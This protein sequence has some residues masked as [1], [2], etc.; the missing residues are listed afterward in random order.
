MADSMHLKNLRI[1]KR[2]ILKLKEIIDVA[3]KQNAPETLA[4]L[5]VLL[6][7][8]KQMKANYEIAVGEALSRIDY[9]T[10]LTKAQKDEDTIL[11]DQDS[12]RN[13][14]IEQFSRIHTALRKI[15]GAVS[16]SSLTGNANDSFSSNIPEVKLP[17]IEIPKF[18]GDPRKFLKFKALF[19]NIV[20]DDANIPSIRK[21]Y[22]LQEALTGKAEE[23]VRDIDVN[24]TSY[25]IAWTELC[26]R[27]DNK[28]SIIR[29]HFSDLFGIL[30]I[31]HESQLR[32]LLDVVAAT[33]RG[34]KMCGEPVENWSSLISYF[35]STRLD[36][37]TR[38]DFENSVEDSSTYPSWKALKQ[39]LD[40]RA[41]VMEENVTSNQ[42]KPKPQTNSK[43]D[44]KETKKSHPTNTSKCCI[45][46][47]GAHLIVECKLF[48]SKTPQERLELIRRKKLCINCFRPNHQ[49]LECRHR[50][51]KTCNNKHHSLLH[52]TTSKVNEQPVNEKTGEPS[53]S[54]SATSQGGVMLLP[55]AV[56]RF[57]C[58]Q[59]SG[60]TR[61]LSDPASEVTMVSTEFVRR[62][63]LKTN[64]AETTTVI[65]GVGTGFIHCNRL[66]SLKLK[67]R[68]NSYEI[69]I[70]CQIVPDAAMKYK[71]SQELVE[72]IK[73]DTNV[74]LAEHMLPYNSIDIIVGAEYCEEYFLEAKLSLEKLILRNS[75]FGW[76]A[77]GASKSNDS[78]QS[79]RCYHTSIVTIEN[80][81]KRLYESE[82]FDKTP[83]ENLEHTRCETHFEKTVCRASSGRFVVQLPLK[84]DL[85]SLS[86][87]KNVAKKSV[88]K[89]LSKSSEITSEYH[90]FIRE[91]HDQGHL[92][93]V[94]ENQL[95][96]DRYFLP[97]L[98]ILKPESSTT[99][100]RVV[101][102]ASF[103][104]KIGNSLNDVLMTG[105]SLQL[106]LFDIIIRFRR[107][108]IAFAADVE[109]MYRQVL[110]NPTHRHL[111]KI[112]YR[113]SE[114]DDFETGVLNTV[115]Y[116][117]A[118]ASFLATKCLFVLADELEKNDPKSASVIR[119]DFYM[120]D[121][122]TG[123][124]TVEEAIQLNRQLY[125]TLI[126]AQFPLRKYISNSSHFLKYI[127]PNLIEKTNHRDFEIENVKVLG[128]RWSPQIDKLSVKLEFSSSPGELTKRRLLSEIAR[129]FDIL[130]LISPVTIRGKL[131]MQKLW[132]LKIDWDDKVPLDVQTRFDEYIADLVKINTFSINRHYFS[133]S[134]EKQF[135]LIGFCD[136]SSVAYCAVVYIHIRNHKNEFKVSLVCAKTKVAPLKPLT[137]P[138][139]EL[140]AARL[141]SLLLAKVEKIL[142][143]N[144]LCKYAFSDSQ[145][146]LC[147]LNK[148]PESW[149]S[150][151][152][153][154][155]R[156]ILQIIP[157]SQWH[158]VRT[159]EN[160]A[161]LATR[162]VSA[163]TFLASRLWLEGPSFLRSAL[164]PPYVG[165][166]IDDALTESKSQKLCLATTS[167]PSDMSVFDQFSSYSRLLAAF[168]YVRRVFR[169]NP[170]ST[171]ILQ[172]NEHVESRFVLIRIVQ[173]HY[174]S[175]ELIALKS[176]TAVHKRSCLLSL[177]PILD[178]HGI[179]RVGGRCRKAS[180]PFANKH[181]II[182]PAKAKFVELLIRFVHWKYF[183]ATKSFVI[184]FLNNE[185]WVVGS[186][187]NEVKRIIRSCVTCIRFRKETMTQL[188][189]QLP[190]T[191]TNPS[192]AFTHI[193]VDFA[194]PFECKCTNHRTTKFYK[195]YMAVFVCFASRAIH[196][197]VVSDL[198]TA[199][200]LDSLKRFI[201][202]RGLPTS[203]TS[204]NGRNFV[205]AK[206]YLDLTAKEIAEFV[207]HENIRW[208]FITPRAPNQGGLWEAAV[209]SAKHHLTRVL[210]G[211][212]LSI[213]GYA[214][215]FGQIESILNSRPISYRRHNSKDFVPITP[216]HLAVGRHLLVNVDGAVDHSSHINH[217]YSH[218]E[219][220]IRSFW[221]AW[222]NDY[223][224]QLQTKSKWKSVQ[225]NIRSGDVV[226]IRDE[227][228]PSQW[229]MGVVETVFPDAEG[230][231]RNAIIRTTS[232]TYQRSVVKL[233]PLIIPDN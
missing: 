230:L 20:H 224:A 45:C 169:R 43:Y 67:S 89:I 109:K 211:T 95:S 222:R 92:S 189:G 91:Y 164:P 209:K 157:A 5:D 76:V 185:H 111:Q 143:A 158:Y 10:D 88:N 12:V 154:R 80:Q 135:E 116:G 199:A 182:L 121:L 195:I 217:Q 57:E 15:E 40:R 193:G 110:V 144:C 148:S 68:L 39:F 188:M 114:D 205:G 70:A 186:L 86:K 71:V 54:C 218:R 77:V 128:L 219:K 197:E 213:E 198:S 72:T 142:V 38:R 75:Q 153:N 31:N 6:T 130:G 201:A 17:K 214:T 133:Y 69:K 96:E 108:S 134:S 32:G 212:I 129:V 52:F 233:V 167:Q 139:L 159:K 103:K 177:S 28:R 11:N 120:D 13:F 14:S 152:A 210:N 136:A 223:F 74:Q 46:E 19:Q 60:L 171:L 176:N 150:F 215:I 113:K 48:L 132:Q 203:I 175:R 4:K 55:T 138:R 141:L 49:A 192:H 179:I 47:T 58:G 102:H 160:P 146:V 106:D 24:E 231:V 35:V 172:P 73:C 123:A 90:R 23:F 184:N 56:V 41:A 59:K 18:D 145:V 207:S 208:H 166:V 117:T 87:T 22:Y 137:V 2:N 221:R 66:C 81:L 104:T 84:G 112:V 220:L 105:P 200:F 127:D 196:I 204:D 99:K 33:L 190:A 64:P 174:Y 98:L 119:T 126:S 50:N 173:R 85:N 101:F 163:Q 63:K 97:Q 82:E 1:L 30:K 156:D 115:I 122:I 194:G 25:S 161:D 232:G 170:S 83:N 62:N 7:E 118:P 107:H 131:L 16:R 165:V 187:S 225:P 100:L 147:W 53:K 9:D 151:V 93:F 124:D 191:R 226:L 227:L 29:L 149:K 61:I 36:D 3:V 125:N 178:E 78:N 44:K 79:Y 37:N 206:N 8:L 26:Q 155:T 51:C 202:R 216:A 229:L 180:L 94:D 65:E 162:G 21:L 228:P 34:L 183:H 140:Q 27:F 181:P 42:T 168:A